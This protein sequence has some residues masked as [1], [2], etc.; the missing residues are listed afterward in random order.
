MNFVMYIKCF[1]EILRDISGGARMQL[2]KLLFNFLKYAGFSHRHE[3]K[4]AYRSDH[5][6]IE[7]EIMVNKF[8]FGKGV[9][10]FNNSHLQNQEYLIL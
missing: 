6:A 10:K 5:S 2:V 8:T 7:L 9:W 4:I 1:T 3:T